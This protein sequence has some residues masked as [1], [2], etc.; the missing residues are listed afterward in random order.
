M[1][2]KKAKKET[3]PLPKPAVDPEHVARL[4]YEFYVRRGGGHGR[5]VEDWL[6]AERILIEQQYT[7]KGSKES[8]RPVHRRVSDERMRL[9]DKFRS[10]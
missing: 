9:E 3:E 7:H 8:K 6:M 1:P 5:D 4:A 10:R 2:S